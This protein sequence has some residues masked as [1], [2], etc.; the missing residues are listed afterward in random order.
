MRI[1]TK[2]TFAAFCLLQ[3]WWCGNAVL[4]RLDR[5]P[6]SHF[7]FHA[8]GSDVGK[9]K[10]CKFKWRQLQI[11]WLVSRSHR[12]AARTRARLNRPIGCS[13]FFVFWSRVGNEKK[14]AFSAP[15]GFGFELYVT[16][17][18]L[19]LTE[20][21]RP[22]S[23]TTQRSCTTQASVPAPVA[24]NENWTQKKDPYDGKKNERKPWKRQ[25][26]LSG[27]T[28]IKDLLLL[29]L[30]LL[31]SAYFSLHSESL[32]QVLI[33]LPLTKE[34]INNSM[35]WSRVLT[36]HSRVETEN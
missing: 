22:G 9:G 17:N 6:L 3:N 19:D 16:A 34:M 5:F 14:C 25:P 11:T 13:F 7:P 8:T 12:S 20:K 28:S 29:L 24:N 2:Y 32:L 4:V 33:T 1:S 30:L 27:S 18:G 15:I 10:R 36:V 26:T 21:I 31:F 35:K 23:C